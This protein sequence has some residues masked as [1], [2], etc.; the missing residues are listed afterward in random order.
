MFAF[1]SVSLARWAKRT[2]VNHTVV[3]L[4]FLHTYKLNDK[5]VVSDHYAIAFNN[6]RLGRVACDVPRRWFAD[7]TFS[8]AAVARPWKARHITINNASRNEKVAIFISQ[9]GKKP[10][11]KVDRVSLTSLLFGTLQEDIIVPALITRDLSM[12]YRCL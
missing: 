6:K 11:T 12:R 9:A 2:D 1:A 5:N 10:A 4:S 3:A 8:E 7:T